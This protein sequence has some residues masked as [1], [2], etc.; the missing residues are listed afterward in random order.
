METQS[1]SPTHVK[2]SPPPQTQQKDKAVTP[3]GLRPTH[4][5]FDIWQIQKVLTCKYT[6]DSMQVVNDL[7]Q[8]KFNLDFLLKQH[9]IL[10][11][12]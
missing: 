6:D 11:R 3:K 9:K 5:I 2:P 4:N 12:T 1:Q 10:D 7:E 8:F